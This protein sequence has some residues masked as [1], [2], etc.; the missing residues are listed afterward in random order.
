MRNSIL[1]SLFVVAGMLTVG[2]ASAQDTKACADKSKEVACV[3]VESKCAPAG[4]AE[5][6][7]EMLTP[8]VLMASMPGVPVAETGAEAKVNC[9]PANCKPANCN[10]ADC[11]PANCNPAQCIPGKE[12]KNTTSV[13]VTDAK[14]AEAV[15]PKKAN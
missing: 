8:K 6:S 1:F 3:K 7:V 4:D 13:K 9:Q 5:A 11:K 10:P 2:E 12:A 15:A 14:L